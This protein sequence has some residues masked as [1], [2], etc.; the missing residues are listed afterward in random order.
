MV[1]PQ[2]PSNKES[3]PG[4]ARSPARSPAASTPTPSATPV[5]TPTS[6]R[7]PTPTKL[8]PSPSQTPTKLIPAPIPTP[9]KSRPTV[10][11]TPSKLVTTS[12]P[13]PAKQGIAPITTTTLSKGPAKIIPGTLSGKMA[14][15][16]PA[17]SAT[18]TPI[19]VTASP[20]LKSAVTKPVSFQPAAKVTASVVSATSSVSQSTAPVTATVALKPGTPTKAVVA[21]LRVIT[22]ATAGTTAATT[23]T[24]KAPVQAQAVIQGQQVAA[25]ALTAQGLTLIRTPVQLPPGVQATMITNAQGVPVMRLQ[26]AGIQSSTPVTIMTT[27]VGAAGL[28]G[29]AAFVRV[30]APISGVST[31]ASGGTLIKL[32]IQ[33]ATTQAVG[34]IKIPV[35]GAQQILTSAAVV[36]SGHGTIQQQLPLTVSPGGQVNVLG[37]QG[38]ITAVGPGGIPVKIALG[39][40][41]PQAHGSTQ[42][43]QVVKSQVTQPV[44]AASPIKLSAVTPTKSQ[45]SASSVAVTPNKVTQAAVT[46]PTKVLTP[47]KTQV[48]PSVT[49]QTRTPVA[50]SSVAHT[51]PKLDLVKTS[52]SIP[53]TA[54]MMS[55][56]SRAMNAG[57]VPGNTNS[58][59]QSQVI[60]S[61]VTVSSQAGDS[62]ISSL[63]QV[64]PQVAKS[65]N[66][67]LSVSANVSQL[68]TTVVQAG[69]ITSST[70]TASQTEK[71]LIRITSAAQTEKPSTQITSVVTATT[72]SSKP[73]A[74]I[75]NTV[76]TVVKTPV[77]VLTGTIPTAT[78]S[79]TSL[80]QKAPLPSTLPQVSTGVAV[81]SASLPPGNHILVYAGHSC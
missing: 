37:Q 43:Q 31:T 24:V 30:A 66:A 45:V 64:Q 56:S 12:S 44:G 70:I 73:V 7:T 5:G 2:L 8:L 69:L 81:T 49:L 9:N 58:T 39:N 77:T 14:V 28:Q 59:V 46:T 35:T 60:K 80:Q 15:S 51:P 38:H 23:T 55:T 57:T 63:A 62:K 71:P 3:Q 67:P 75:S 4:P 40:V 6:T 79:T 19:K 17:M 11:T 27:Q 25:G 18:K 53:V 52:S 48:K 36:A 10:S 29:A 68:Q 33:A 72:T 20:V 32:P 34:T 42:I 26:G 21:Q 74:P 22:T 65:I 47:D 1:Q 78:V 61:P 54:A 16:A 50:V 76:S 41:Q 13:A